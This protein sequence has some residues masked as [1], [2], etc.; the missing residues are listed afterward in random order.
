MQFFDYFYE[1]NQKL[2]QS[3]EENCEPEGIEL[4]FDTLGI[5]NGII[6]EAIQVGSLASE[7]RQMTDYAGTLLPR[8]R[9]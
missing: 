2:K 3:E 9:C 8:V 7:Y 5:I 4:V 6:D 1:Q